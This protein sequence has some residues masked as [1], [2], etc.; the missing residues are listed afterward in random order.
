MRTKLTLVMLVLALLAAGIAGVTVMWQYH[1]YANDTTDATLR[2]GVQSAALAV[3]LADWR[4]LFEPAAA[5]S[6]YYLGTL[7]RLETV[8]KTFE[9]TYTYVMGR[10][11]DGRIV[12]LFDTQNLDP[13]A[14]STFLVE[15]RD[16]PE[17]VAAAFAGPGLVVSASTYTD[18]FGTFRSAFLPVLGAGG[19]VEAVVG[20]DLDVSFLT[21][22]FRRTLLSFGVALLAAMGLLAGFVVLVA[23]RLVKP[24][25]LMADAAD[26]IAAGDL[27]RMIEVRGRDEVAMLGRSF[28]RMSDQLGAVIGRIREASSQ[29]ASSSEQLSG[30]ARALS[31]S[32]LQQASTLEETSAAME[33]LT[34]SVDQVA[35]HARSQ[36][37]SV[38][39]SS[40]HMQ[41]VQST[42]RRVTETLETVS[43]AS[44]QSIDRAKTGA[45]AVSRTVEAIRSISTHSDRIAGIAAVIGGIADQS[46]LLALNAA[47]EAA[48]AGEHG[49]GFAV[50]A[51]EVAKLA[52]RS[53]KSTREIEEL[54][55]SSGRDV[56]T[57]VE[58]AQA[59]LGAMDGII[60]G[61]RRTGEMVAAL[62]QEVTQSTD[63][64]GKASRASDAIGEVSRSIS[65]ATEE[66]STGAR[67]VA[68]AVEN[69]NGMTQSVSSSAEQLSA[70][71]QQL[72]GLAAQL[73]S[74]VGTFQLAGNAAAPE[75]PAAQRPSGER[76]LARS[77]A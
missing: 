63:A 57:G 55:S 26:R 13:E 11:D 34:S 74:M 68:A 54:V 50:V 9:L 8:R 23:G 27:R 60:E 14:E 65:V 51:D 32:A 43:D 3:D 45:D 10:D 16:Y 35:E 38:S 72:S 28:N 31:E 2:R 44:R 67:Q 59:A 77:A 29:V 58:I 76:P 1:R 48:R 22:L 19:E 75:F 17:E 41:L 73:Q 37:D 12:F 33:E 30:T 40:G 66:Q 5:R 4:R 46:N 18:E 15:Y 47:I 49:R 64:L 42:S 25:R 24:I 36:A 6:D 21:A 56:G 62:A 71:T 53:S 69:V 52:E 39:Q 20:V 7:E 61:A 70:A